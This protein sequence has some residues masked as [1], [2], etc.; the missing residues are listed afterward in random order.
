MRKTLVRNNGK[1]HIIE[2]KEYEPERQTLEIAWK[3]IKDGMTPE[4]SYRIWYAEQKEIRK[5][6]YLNKKKDG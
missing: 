4:E 2:P 1:W 6:L 3:Q 5:V